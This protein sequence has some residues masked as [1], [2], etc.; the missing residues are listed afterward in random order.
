VPGTSPAVWRGSCSHQARVL[1]LPCATEGTFQ[2]WGPT[3]GCS[4]LVF[5]LQLLPRL[6][7]KQMMM[8]MWRWPHGFTGLDLT[9]T[10]KS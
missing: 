8:T 3:G 6:D 2:V 1:A 4:S 9:K 7:G 5:H 10:Q